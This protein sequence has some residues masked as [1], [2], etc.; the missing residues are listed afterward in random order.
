MASDSAARIVASVGII[1]NLVGLGAE[2]VVRL[3]VTLFFLYFWG[4][5]YLI[6]VASMLSIGFIC[7]FILPIIGLSQ[8]EPATKGRATAILISSGIIGVVLGAFSASFGTM[9]AILLLVAG[10][11]VYSWQPS[12]PQPYQP[13]PWEA[14][15]QPVVSTA[16][17]GGK[18]G[19][20]TPKGARFCVSCGVQL[21]GDEPSCPDCGTPI[22]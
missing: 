2:L 18:G 8:I 16:D 11:L 1:L 3:T 7:G 9:G 12:K 6:F 21:K 19:F 4:A 5:S 10:A 14:A 22:R 17:N 13:L 15:A 20:I